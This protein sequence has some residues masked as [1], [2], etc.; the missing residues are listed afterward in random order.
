M[1]A[2]AGS[3]T[4]QLLLFNSSGIDFLLIKQIFL[5]TEN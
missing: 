1:I 4:V 2:S 3:M 5:L